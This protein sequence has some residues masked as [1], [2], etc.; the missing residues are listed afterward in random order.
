MQENWNHNTPFTNS[1]QR[2]DLAK[3]LLALG[4]SGREGSGSEALTK[5][6]HLIPE[7]AANR[8][9]YTMVWSAIEDAQEAWDTT[10]EE[11][12]EEHQMATENCSVAG[13]ILVEDVHTHSQNDPTDDNNLAFQMLFNIHGNV[14]RSLRLS[15]FAIESVADWSVNSRWS[16]FPLP[17]NSTL[18]TN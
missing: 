14:V 3:Q 15:S 7:I 5:A 4:R 18:E 2:R 13:M 17:L 16:C 11:K 1:D 10:K 8:N 6:L 9:E 12:Q